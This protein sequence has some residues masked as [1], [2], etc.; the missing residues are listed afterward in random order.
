MTSQLIVI[1]QEEPKIHWRL[2]TQ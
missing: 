2:H 1:N